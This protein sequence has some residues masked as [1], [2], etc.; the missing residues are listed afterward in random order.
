VVACSSGY[1]Q[2]VRRK[3]KLLQRWPSDVS[4]PSRKSIK[5]YRKKLLAHIGAMVRSQL[6]RDCSLGLSPFFRKQWP[7]KDRSRPHATTIHRSGTEG[8]R[9]QVTAGRWMRLLG[10]EATD[11]T[12]RVGQTGP[13]RQ[14]ADDAF[15]SPIFSTVQLLN[16]LLSQTSRLSPSRHAPLSHRYGLKT[17]HAM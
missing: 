4:F 12:G 5:P 17:L 11:S 15:A 2:L 13:P 3:G 6:G 10:G 8:S 16:F 9:R 7:S 1:G 14:K